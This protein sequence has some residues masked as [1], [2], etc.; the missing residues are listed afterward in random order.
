MT[1]VYRN[2]TLIGVLA[3]CL[4][5]QA[6]SAESESDK[7]KTQAHDLRAKAGLLHQQALKAIEEAEAKESESDKDFKEAAAL[8]RKLDEAEKASPD[9]V[10]ARALRQQAHEDQ[11]QSERAEASAKVHAQRAKRDSERSEDA[12]RTLGDL[13]GKNADASA[14]KL[15]EEDDAQNQRK[16]KEEEDGAKQFETEAARLKKNAAELLAQADK[17]DPGGKD[18]DRTEHA[19]PGK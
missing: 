7:L 15:L 5:A 10:K 12:K 11:R 16:A 8:D 3:L 19:M 14:L 9:Q 2:A 6:Q 13:K 4:G 1:A 18:K 17:L